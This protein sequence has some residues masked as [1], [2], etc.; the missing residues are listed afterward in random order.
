MNNPN[1]IQ[2]WTV[3]SNDN[4]YF[5]FLDD[6]FAYKIDGSILKSSNTNFSFKTYLDLNSIFDDRVKADAKNFVIYNV[7]GYTYQLVLLD[8]AYKDFIDIY[9][10]ESIHT[11]D[12]NLIVI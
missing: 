8:S 2:T 1:L 9:D 4:L 10:N 7:Y 3:G 6:K 11:K 5:K 12:K